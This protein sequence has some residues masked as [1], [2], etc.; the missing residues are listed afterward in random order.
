[1]MPKVSFQVKVTVTDIK[2]ISAEINDCHCRRQLSACVVG[3][4]RVS[5]L[6]LF[7]T[8][9]IFTIKRLIRHLVE[10]TVDM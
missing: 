8:A 4:T 3:F 2:L 1:M 10:M 7:V 9:L 5:S 6:V